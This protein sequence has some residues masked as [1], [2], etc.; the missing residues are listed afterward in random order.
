[1]PRAVPPNQLQLTLQSSALS[2][3]SAVKKLHLI[4]ATEPS[5]VRQKEEQ[6]QHEGRK[7]HE[8][9]EGLPSARGDPNAGACEKGEQPAGERSQR[10]V[11]AP[12][13]P[14]PPSVQ[15]VPPISCRCSP[16]RTSASSASSALRL[17]HPL[18]RQRSLEHGEGAAVLR[19][20]RDLR[21]NAVL[22][23]A[24]RRSP[25]GSQPSATK[26]RPAPKA[27]ENRTRQPLQPG[28]ATP[29]S[30]PPG[31]RRAR[32]RRTPTARARCSGATRSTFGRP[33]AP[34]GSAS[35]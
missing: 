34:I 19:A 25:H 8:G 32:R 12:S 16:L 10:P 4:S 31:T 22:P 14:M 18:S 24:S 6:P 9:R 13:S 35:G 26:R 28:P 33:R 30:A 7:G 5:V 23:A 1:M 21:V 29:D 17:L 2:A 3:R 15:A 11:R 27:T 20:L